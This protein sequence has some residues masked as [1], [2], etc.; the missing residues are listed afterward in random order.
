MLL[1][2][3]VPVYIVLLFWIYKLIYK[4]S[5]LPDYKIGISLLFNFIDSV[6]GLISLTYFFTYSYSDIEFMTKSLNSSFEYYYSIFLMIYFAIT[7]IFTLFINFPTL[8]L[9]H[10]IIVCMFAHLLIYDHV[11]YIPILMAFVI[12]LTN[13]CI[14]YYTNVRDTFG[15]IFI[16]LGYTVRIILTNIMTYSLTYLYLKDNSYLVEYI[17]YVMITLLINYWYLTILNGAYKIMFK[18]KKSESDIL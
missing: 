11:C 7:T 1:H 8:V 18:T 15:P 14:I 6:I 17:A 16:V 3:L 4:K 5:T 10:F 9:H 12:E 13:I 2:Y